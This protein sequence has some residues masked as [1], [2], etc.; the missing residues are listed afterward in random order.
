L[1]KTFYGGIGVERRMRNQIAQIIALG[2]RV[3]LE[4][5]A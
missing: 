2:Y 5:T 3:T 1:L 4:A